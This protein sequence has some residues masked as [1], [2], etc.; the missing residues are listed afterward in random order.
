MDGHFVRWSGQSS[1]YLPIEPFE[2]K[3]KTYPSLEI[4]IDVIDVLKVELKR[5]GKEKEVKKE[6]EGIKGLKVAEIENKEEQAAHNEE[7]ENKRE[8][9]VEVI[10]DLIR[11]PLRFSPSLCDL[12]FTGA[13]APL[14]R[15]PSCR[16]YLSGTPSDSDLSCHCKQERAVAIS[17][18]PHRCNIA[19]L[20]CPATPATTGRLQPFLIDGIA[21]LSPS[22]SS[23][24]GWRSKSQ[25]AA[26]SSFD[27]NYFLFIAFPAR[28]AR[29]RLTDSLFT[30]SVSPATFPSISG[31]VSGRNSCI[32]AW[33]LPS[34]P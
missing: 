25:G 23:F 21:P 22:S 24:T 28:S 34:K 2:H 12:P 20:S 8:S 26:I 29:D 4:L 18:L 33:L 10:E 7:G 27:R 3:G 15:P 17:F 14:I 9:I 5:Q 13:Q 6:E 31:Q 19:F 32:G 1:P 16:H 11:T 30:S